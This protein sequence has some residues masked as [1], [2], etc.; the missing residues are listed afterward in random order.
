MKK[1]RILFSVLLLASILTS[2]DDSK[3]GDNNPA[4][5]SNAA[6]SYNKSVVAITSKFTPELSHERDSLVTAL[7]KLPL[8]KK[9]VTDKEVNQK[10]L[11]ALTGL[12]MFISSND[13]TFVFMTKE[14]TTVIQKDNDQQEFVIANLVISSRGGLTPEI[15]DVYY[16]YWNK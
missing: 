16:R 2:C 7:A 4:S 6:D 5:S 11:A 1:V 8:Y 3:S 9:L 14:L 12:A 13:G 10:Y 15:V